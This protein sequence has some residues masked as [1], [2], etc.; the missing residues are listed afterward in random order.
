M[1]TTA[2]DPSGFV[3]I[4]GFLSL[5]L[6][7]TQMSHII[8]TNLLFLIIKVKRRRNN[9]THTFDVCIKF[10]DDSYWLVKK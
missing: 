3:E 1:K 6:N 4:D 2:R 9:M 10:K 5:V 8:A 7:G